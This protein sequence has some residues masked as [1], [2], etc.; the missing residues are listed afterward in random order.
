MFLNFISDPKTYA[1]LVLV[2]N[3]GTMAFD[4]QIHREHIDI[5]RDQLDFEQ[6]CVLNDIAVGNVISLRGAYVHIKS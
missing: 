3:T 5:Y 6:P 1:T 2:D 4:M